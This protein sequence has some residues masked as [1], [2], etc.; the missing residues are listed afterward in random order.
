MMAADPAKPPSAA[1]LRRYGGRVVPT[2]LRW[3]GRLAAWLVYRLIR[4]VTATAR[5]RFEGP[6]G[7][8]EQIL[9]Q[10][11]IFS[12]WHNRLAMALPAYERVVRRERPARRMAAIV[13][14]S[15]DGALVARV[16]EHFGVEPVRGSTSR[17]GPQ[18]LRELVSQAERGFDLAIT[19]DGPRGPCYEVQ[20]GVIA[21]A[22]LTGLPVIPTSYSVNPKYRLKSWDRFQIPLPFASWELRVAEPIRIPRE[23]DE[24]ERRRLRAELERRMR[25]ITPD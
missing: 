6:P 16:L 3:H 5:F 19:P 21:M 10:P 17:R 11:V 23:A 4:T 2:R 15:K 25:A 8:R 20:E 24:E 14:A 1:P 9:D 7:V 13:S 18:A 12:I 22:Q